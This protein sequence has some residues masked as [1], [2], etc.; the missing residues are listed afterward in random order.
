MAESVVVFLLDK[1]TPL[2]QEE[3]KLLRGIIDE[4]VYVKDE[5]E[6]MRA[7]LR[8]A[9]SMEE[10]DEE[11]KIWVKQVREVAYDTEDVLDEFQLR[12]RHH[13]GDGFYGYLSKI[14]GTIKNLKVRHRFA[15]EL[16]GIKSR[17]TNISE[18]HQRYR[19]RLNIPEKV[20]SF[21]PRYDKA[22]FELRRDAFLID[23]GQLVG[24]E[25]PKEELIKRVLGVE[26]R[27]QVI[28]VVGMGGLGKTTA[29]SKVYYDD[30]LRKEFQHHVW[31]T[32]SQS[33]M[34]DEILRDIVQ[35][36]FE[37]A[38]QPLPHGAESTDSSKLKRIIVDFLHGKRYLMVLDDVWQMDGWDAL[39]HAFPDSNCG[40]RL[41]LTTRNSEVAST[42]TIEP[43]G[44]VYNLKP[45]SFEESWTLFC[46]K[47]FRE[48]SCPSHLEKI[49]QN[50][51]KRCEGLPLAIVAIGGM[52]AMK[53]TIRTDE[54]EMVERSLRTELE[55]NDKLNSMKTILLLSFND[56]P[57][58]LKYCFLYL[59]IFPEDY[60]IE[61][62]RL[63]R[64]W[65]AEGFVQVKECRTVEEVGEFYFNE[66]VNRSLIQVSEKHDD[67][68]IKR[69]RVHDLLR[70]IILLKS[71]DQNFAAIT[72]EEN[73]SLPKRVRRLSVHRT[74]ENIHADHNFSKLRSLFL[75]GVKDNSVSS[76][77]SSFSNGG[78]RLLKVLDCR[79]VP[80][81][82][83]PMDI[84]KLNNLR[85][86]NLRDTSVKSIP[87][88]IGNLQNLETLD[89]RNTYVEELPVEI[90]Q[91]HRLR[92]I[93][94][95]R[96]IKEFSI[97]FEV[98][99][100]RALAGIEILSSLQSLCY[101]EANQGDADIM[102]SLGQLKEL[103]RLGV[104]QL[105]AEDGIA[106][107]SSIEKLRHLH[108]LSIISS[109]A[110]EILN[111]QSISLPPP[112][113]Q[114]LYL[115][116]CLEKLPN[117]ICSLPSLTK[118]VLRWSGLQVDPLENLQAL[119]NLVD[120]QLIQAYQGET[121]SF[122]A[123]SFQKLK[124][125]ALRNLDKLSSVEIENGALPQLRDLCFRGCKLVEEVPSGIEGL[126]NLKYVDFVDM[127]YELVS[128]LSSMQ[129]KDY[130][131]VKHVPVVLIGWE[132][133]INGE[134][135]WGMD[136]FYI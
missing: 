43:G 100:F 121:L 69:C 62:T 2:L 25:T 6:R 112:C 55:G 39:K 132:K 109:E 18:G 111:L 24:I 93:L 15:S 32:V 38:K 82:T 102:K 63:I 117:W 75:F 11:I 91:L 5:L 20:S 77:Y 108:S 98:V 33:F 35:Q 128:R 29:V 95:Y 27:L 103:R 10:G 36:L 72:S 22:W 50:I 129:G 84:G 49:C 23:E 12:L 30:E 31:I 70:E 42:C 7:F 13:R 114:R 4:V 64:L 104:V 34:L 120:L 76:A 16:R 122:K 134:V 14:A 8:T 45:L 71:M 92:H 59:S 66:L 21:T 126:T 9:D 124:N 99:G 86:L 116:G 80:L 37:E 115:S 135:G 96:V 131:N 136:G 48:N 73:R 54:W 130:L 83:L 68:R 94:L 51:L 57:Y 79:G 1:L 26:S 127:S 17:L 90:L 44:M 105:R 97:S 40:S 110:E 133:E 123:G 74:L 119:P 67:G 89:L 118:L 41:M 125:L 87:C 58:H 106:L 107:S 101:I 65:I 60:L 78:L 52:L 3:V 28:A 53:D 88:S 46:Q 47:T 56:L 113:L 19:Y 61:R 81:D 85:Y